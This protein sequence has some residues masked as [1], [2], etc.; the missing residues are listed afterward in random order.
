MGVYEPK[1][2]RWKK[3]S[4]GMSVSEI[5][6]LKRLEDE[7]VKLKR[8]VADLTLGRA[9]RQDVLRRQW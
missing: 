8:L 7:N 5:P 3:Q 4:A 2:Y 1:S 6:R 9:V